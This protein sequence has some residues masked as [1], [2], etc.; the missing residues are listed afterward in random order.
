MVTKQIPYLKKV[1][2]EYDVGKD[3]FNI[4][5]NLLDNF[6]GFLKFYS[7]EYKD[8]KTTER[9]RGQFHK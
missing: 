2:K 9:I 3:K 7:Y 4:S 6:I 1:N 8:S 5:Y